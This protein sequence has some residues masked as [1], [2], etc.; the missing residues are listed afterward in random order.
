MKK[1]KNMEIIKIGKGVL[2]KINSAEEM[3]VS[4]LT[5]KTLIKIIRNVGKGK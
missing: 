3:K 1:E 2:S 5:F 4:S